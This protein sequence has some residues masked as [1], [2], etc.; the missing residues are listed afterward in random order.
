MFV[1]HYRRVIWEEYK[2]GLLDTIVESLREN[3]SGLSWLWDTI[4]SYRPLKDLA[5]AY[6]TGDVLFKGIFFSVLNFISLC[7]SLRYCRKALLPPI[8]PYYEG[9]IYASL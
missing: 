7:S 2:P 8:L 9:V 4:V 1:E 3:R 6:I 5:N